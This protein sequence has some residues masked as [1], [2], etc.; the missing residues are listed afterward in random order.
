[1][2]EDQDEGRGFQVSA[3]YEEIRMYKIRSTDHCQLPDRGGSGQGM[4]RTQDPS[5]ATEKSLGPDP[6]RQ[7]SSSLLLWAPGKLPYVCMKQ[8]AGVSVLICG[9]DAIQ[10]LMTIGHKN[11]ISRVE[12]LIEVLHGHIKEG[13]GL[14]ESGINIRA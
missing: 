6:P 12:I 4:V 10:I 5:S 2:S 14:R 3:V 11:R 9:G 13:V 1:M 8:S 7:E